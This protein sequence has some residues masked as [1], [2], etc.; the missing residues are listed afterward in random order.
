MLFTS[1]LY[2]A[3]IHRDL[4]SSN[5]LLDEEFIAKLAD[6]GLCKIFRGTNTTK[7]VEISHGDLAINVVT[8]ANLIE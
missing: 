4:K 7:K 8:V 5:I 3:I 1:R 6:F 2:L